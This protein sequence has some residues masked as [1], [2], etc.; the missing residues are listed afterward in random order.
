MINWW[1]YP[2]INNFGSY[3]DPEGAFPKPDVN[4]IAP[5]GTKFTAPL[6]GVVSGIDTTSPFGD[7]VTVNLDSPINDSA[8]H[9]AF[10]H[11]SSIAPGLQVGEHINA[12]DLL[13]IGGGNQSTSGADPGFALTSS[14]QYGFGAGWYN[15]VQGSWINPKL[16]PTT[17]L[18]SLSVAPPPSTGSSGCN[19]SN[20]IY[21]WICNLFSPDRLTRTAIVIFGMILL[22]IAFY[23]FFSGKGDTNVNLQQQP[24]GSSDEGAEAGE[25]SSSAEMAEVAAV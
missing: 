8:T 22:V 13:G 20:P 6:S 10:L 24:S 25:G 19:S 18:N 3:P 17:L 4:I 7:V 21:G 9:Y 11:L 14:D 1:Q 2:E 16:D 12:G 23:L 5:A 15:N